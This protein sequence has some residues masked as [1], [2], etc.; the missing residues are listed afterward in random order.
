MRGYSAEVIR[1][2][3]TH[4]HTFQHTCTTAHTAA[5]SHRVATKLAEQTASCLF[6]IFS[7]CLFTDPHKLR[8]ESQC[9]VSAYVCLHAQPCVNLSV[10][11]TRLYPSVIRP[12]FTRHRCPNEASTCKLRGQSALSLRC[13]ARFYPADTPR[14]VKPLGDQQSD[15]ESRRTN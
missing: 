3:Y 13:T 4:T 10:M 1:S 15:V 8:L 11:R 9:D 5:E 7:G 2:G 14:P 6:V 12:V